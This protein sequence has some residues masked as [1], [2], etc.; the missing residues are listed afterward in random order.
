[1]VWKAQRRRRLTKLRADVYCEGDFILHLDSDMIISRPVLRKD[2]L[3]LGRPMLLFTSYREL[4]ES[5][6]AWQQGTS[7]ALG[8][9]VSFEFSRSA[10][11]V[12]PRSIY[13]RAR[14]FLESKH[15]TDLVSFLATRRGKNM[16]TLADP[17]DAAKLFSD[18]NFLGAFLY[19]HAREEMA[20]VPTSPTMRDEGVFPIVPSFV[21][22]GNARLVK[23]MQI[24]EMLKDGPREMA[25][26][27]RAGMATG[28]CSQIDS[29]VVSL[30]EYA[31]QA[32]VASS[33]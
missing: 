2:L 11:H 25:D 16:G 1:M 26:K 18:F 5:Q 17:H 4:S 14:A 20:F 13:A 29:Y 33:S 9:H 22:Q 6:S 32:W 10:V 12:Y 3:W 30:F 31:A 7:Y 27:L 15:Q 23:E 21:C 28:E 8:R 19:Y 24:A